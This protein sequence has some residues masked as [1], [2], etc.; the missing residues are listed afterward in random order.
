MLYRD[1][2]AKRMYFF[3]IFIVCQVLTVF[4]TIISYMQDTDDAFFFDNLANASCQD[5]VEHTLFSSHDNC[6]RGMTGYMMGRLVVGG[7]V[8]AGI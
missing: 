1:T 8:L 5:T 6:V 4:I 7:L 2:E 3:Y